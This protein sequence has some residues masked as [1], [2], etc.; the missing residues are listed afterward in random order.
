MPVGTVFPD[1]CVPT[2]FGIA[3][4]IVAIAALALLVR[5]WRQRRRE[6]R[7]GRR[8]DERGGRLGWVRRLT[9]GD[10]INLA[11][12]ALSVGGIVAA[13]VRCSDSP[14]DVRIS[15]ADSRLNP[16]EY[17]D[18]SDE[19]VCLVSHE[20][21]PVSLAGW[22]LH[23]AERRINV[24]PDLT[25]EPGAAARVHPGEGTNSHRDLYG[26][27]G[28]PQWR[29]EG[30]QIS[31]LDSEGQEV[32]AVGYS[33]R[34]DDDGS[35]ECG[36]S[37]TKST[38]LTL[39]IT[40]PEPGEAIESATVTVRGTVTP[41]GVVRAKL[42]H[43][44][45]SDAGGEVAQVVSGDGAAHFTVD[46]RLDPGENHIR[47]WA[48]KP[49]AEPVFTGVAVI[50]KK[51]DRI[52]T[53]EPPPPPPPPPPCDPG[54]EGAC[55]DPEAYDYDCAGGEGDGPEYVEGPVTIVGEDRFDLDR[56]GD[57]IAC[58]P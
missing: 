34:K 27:K 47:V 26:E 58:E 4:A 8:P 30:G 45:E 52:S 32:D 2:W 33:E 49:G 12:L 40:S 24:L 51:N 43:D 7:E 31:L 15:L 11:L 25:L 37:V 19:Y 16:A 18:P 44:D 17:D 13:A 22:E 50:R 28:S 3:C 39:K 6:R 1:V 10:W 53:E 21:D 46:V 14:P 5:S 41:G 9:P 56:N 36:S 35:G 20:D 57:G 54:Y 55:L 42:D 38:E 29:N 23:G 48:E